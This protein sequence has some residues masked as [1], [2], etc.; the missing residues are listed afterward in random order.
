MDEHNKQQKMNE[1]IKNI[2]LRCQQ[3]DESYQLKNPEKYMDYL[4]YYWQ[5]RNGKK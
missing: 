1:E 3:V 2:E 4:N 5:E